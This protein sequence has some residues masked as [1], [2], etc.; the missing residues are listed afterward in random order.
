MGFDW[1]P[2]ISYILEQATF[3]LENYCTDRQMIFDEWGCNRNKFGSWSCAHFT[4]EWYP[5]NGIRLEAYNSG[6]YK[7][8]QPIW[9]LKK[10]SLDWRIVFDEWHSMNEIRLEAY[11]L[12][13]SRAERLSSWRIIASTVKPYSMNGIQLEA[14]NPRGYNFGMEL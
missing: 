2:T 14:Y 8:A 11:N 10:Y 12:L 4:G 1:S 5:M 7:P 13:P 3:E 9:E 6:P